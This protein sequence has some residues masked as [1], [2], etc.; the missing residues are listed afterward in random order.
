MLNYICCLILAQSSLHRSFLNSLPQ[1]RPKLPRLIHTSS[2]RTD[3]RTAWELALSRAHSWTLLCDG[4][5]ESISAAK[6]LDDVSLLAY[7]EGRRTYNTVGREAIR[8]GSTNL[9]VLQAWS[10][11]CLTDFEDGWVLWKRGGSHGEAKSEGGESRELHFGR[12]E[13]ANVWADLRTGV[14]GW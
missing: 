12:L 2:L 8:V 9:T 13:N 11:S 7:A 10:A 6:S 4:H 14:Y 5:G 3:Q 1:S